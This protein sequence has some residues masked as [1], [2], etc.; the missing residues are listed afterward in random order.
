MISK[1]LAVGVSRRSILRSPA[2]GTALV[3]ALVT[4]PK[5]ALPKTRREIELL[6]AFVAGTAYYDAERALPGLREG[7]RLVLRRQPDNPHDAKA[8]EV[9]TQSGLKLGYVPR[10]DNSALTAL[11]DDGRKLA[12][13]VTAVRAN[14]YRDI[15][16]AIALVE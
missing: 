9:F 13:R 16:I 2:I 3:T 8:I 1:F 7:E 5:P 4:A 11:A 12:A 15:G 6:R 10:L 14:H